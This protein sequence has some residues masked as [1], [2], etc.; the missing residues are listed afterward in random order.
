MKPELATPNPN[1]YVSPSPVRI[2]TRHSS[3]TP[4]LTFAVPPAQ[5]VLEQPRV[6]HFDRQRPLVGL[7]EPL[8]LHPKPVACGRAGSLPAGLG[9]CLGL[10]RAEEVLGPACLDVEGVEEL[11]T[12]VAVIGEATKSWRSKSGL[13]YRDRTSHHRLGS[14]WLKAYRA[15][16]QAEQ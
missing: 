13:S 5:L 12:V 14:E 3:R 2:N 7:L 15:A 1:L 9:L 4:K 8:L 6:P 11:E 16:R 10:G